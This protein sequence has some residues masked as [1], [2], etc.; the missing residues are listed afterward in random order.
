[1]LTNGTIRI[2]LQFSYPVLGLFKA[3]RTGDV[4]DNCCCVSAPEQ[5]NNSTQEQAAHRNKQRTGTSSAQ[6]H[7]QQG[8]I[9]KVLRK[10]WLE[11]G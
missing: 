7:S 1:L 4:V 3:L 6:E 5:H 11:V 9:A 10:G 2:L 8:W